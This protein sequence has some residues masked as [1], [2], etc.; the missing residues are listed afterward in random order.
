MRWPWQRREMLMPWYGR[1]TDRARMVDRLAYGEA[2]RFNQEYIGT[3]HIL[4]GL[5][6]LGSGV[7]W[8][9]LSS[10]QVDLRMMRNEVEKMSSPLPAEV[11][12]GRLSLTPRARN[13]ITLAVEESRGLQHAHVGTEHLLL[14]LL[15]EQQG[16]AYQILQKLGLNLDEA[17]Q[18]VCE[19][20]TRK[21]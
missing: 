8:T 11:P 15:R 19:L 6:K 1:F 9:L 18:R 4:L 21:S 20:A 12:A 17:R 3:E 2:I 14:G 16:V 10:Y 5:V 7:A 13:I